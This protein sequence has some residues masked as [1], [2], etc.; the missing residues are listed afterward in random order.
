VSE[1][2]RCSPVAEAIRRLVDAWNRRDADAF[3]S[4]FTPTAEYVTG[5]GQHIRG[6]ESIA[7]LVDRNRDQPRLSVVEGPFVDHGGTTA[8]VRFAW[9]TAGD[10]RVSRRGTIACTLVWHGKGWLIDALH[11][12]E[13][14]GARDSRTRRGRG[15]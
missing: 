8:K 1:S 11:N 9:V 6:R 5:A 12:E 3:G 14:G 13:S 4:A 7:A 2:E 15:A 10:A